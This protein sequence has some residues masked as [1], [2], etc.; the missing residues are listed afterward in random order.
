M[1]A[2]QPVTLRDFNFAPLLGLPE[3][4]AEFRLM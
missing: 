1:T 3:M 4:L 2:D